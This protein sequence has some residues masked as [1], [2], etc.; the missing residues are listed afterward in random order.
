MGRRGTASTSLFERALLVLLFDDPYNYRCTASR[1][2]CDRSCVL[3]TRC[4]LS[5]EGHH[6]ASDIIKV[7]EHFKALRF[8]DE[9][10]YLRSAR[11]T[12]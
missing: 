2:S 8:A 3:P 10:I 12:S 7:L 6:A 9:T 5:G 1:R 4:A 11:S